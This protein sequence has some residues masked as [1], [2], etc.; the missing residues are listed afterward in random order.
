[1]SRCEFCDSTGWLIALQ[2]TDPLTD[3]AFLCNRCN[4]AEQRKLKDVRW[5][6]DG[7]A[8]DYLPR[9]PS[10]ASFQECDALIAAHRA[11]LA[12]SK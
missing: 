1:M 8:A 6:H 2:R 11:T 3:V 12:A 9:L 7:Y 4:V 10:M 5:W